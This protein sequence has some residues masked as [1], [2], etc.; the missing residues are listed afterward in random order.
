MKSI[1]DSRQ[2]LKFV[3]IFTAILIAIAKIT[4]LY[5]AL[6]L[7]CRQPGD[8]FHPAGRGVGKEPVSY[9]HLD[10]YKRQGCR[11]SSPGWIYSRPAPRRASS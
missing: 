8:R 11:K 4:T 10:V 5:P 6:V 3:F 7:R 9:T 1:Y 2:R